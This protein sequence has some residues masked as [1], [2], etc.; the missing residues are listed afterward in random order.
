MPARPS[1]PPP[2]KPEAAH[3]LLVDW[4]ET[5]PVT[6]DRLRRVLVLGDRAGADLLASRAPAAQVDRDDVP[7]DD[8]EG[9]DLV[10]VVGW[11][12]PGADMAALTAAVA[13]GGALL[14]ITPVRADASGATGRA[15]GPVVGC[16]AAG[17][18]LVAF[19]DLSESAGADTRSGQ[20]RWLRATCRRVSR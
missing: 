1:R 15:A 7:V 2:A 16:G 17:L 3:P 20:R 18:L 5:G 11:P 12:P 8:G 14:L 4:L 9:Y 19:D 6:V 10:A 13:D